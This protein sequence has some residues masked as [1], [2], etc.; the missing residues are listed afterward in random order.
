MSGPWD[1]I[2]VGGG[3]A[4]L[5]AALTLGRARRRTLLVDAG[6]PSNA[7][8]HAVG[9]LLGNDRRPPA[10]LYAAARTELAAYPSV[11]YRPG[12]VAVARADGG[13]FTAVLADGAEERSRRLLLAAG[14]EYRYPP[15]P[16][17]AERWGASVFH[18]PFCHGWELRERHLA[19]LVTGPAELPRVLM[20]R[21]WSDE[22]VVLTG[23]A[24]VLDRGD[25]ESL[26]AAGIPVDD[27]PI[28][29]V[30][31]PGR[32]MTALV[33]D[34]GAERACAGLLVPVE[35]HQRTGLVRGLG[36]RLVA[37]PLSAE[38]VEIGPQGETSLPGLFAAGDLL[39]QAPSV[40]GA[41]ASGLTAA[42][43]VVHSLYG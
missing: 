31:G 20:L 13:G 1:C 8:A 41:I 39:P 36:A 43:G 11:E 40:A 34:D 30:E 9:G 5:S 32:A 38:Y 6:R 26:H 15:I 16:G 21:S 22:V 37:G 7:V 33:F 27:R 23:G 2:V 35:L 3:A 25:R 4:G 10:E 14:M 24:D 12:E 29:R 18:C 42:A 17:A 28:A 19:V